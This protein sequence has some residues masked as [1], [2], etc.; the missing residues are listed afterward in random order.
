[1]RDSVRNIGPR[2]PGKLT[3][4]NGEIEAGFL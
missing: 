1:L 4:V 2:L 3:A